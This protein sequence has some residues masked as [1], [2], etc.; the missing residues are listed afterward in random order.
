MTSDVIIAMATFGGTLLG[1]MGI[2]Y[3]LLKE[4]LGDGTAAKA[5]AQDAQ[6]KVATLRD[7]GVKG[8]EKKLDLHIA[9]DQTQGIQAKLEIVI[10][11]NNQ[12]LRD[13]KV[14]DRE[15]GQEKAKVDAAVDHLD[16]LHAAFARCR[17]KGCKQ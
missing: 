8:L 4:R 3:V 10:G 2:S 11:Q 13:I 15:V 1:S 17:D 16:K 12:I 14:L 6:E 5:M 7:E 9:G